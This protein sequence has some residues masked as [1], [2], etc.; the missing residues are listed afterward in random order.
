MDDEVDKQPPIA[1]IEEQRAVYEKRSRLGAI[2]EADLLCG[3]G[4]AEDVCV[5]L[6]IECV[7]VKEEP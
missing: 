4:A 1:S 5:G 2:T 7:N 6:G 3:Y